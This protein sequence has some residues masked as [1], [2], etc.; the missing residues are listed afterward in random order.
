MLE[1]TFF[2][3]AMTHDPKDKNT[4]HVGSPNFGD[5]DVFNKYVDE[6]FE[7]RWFTNS[8]VVEQEFEQRLCEY[9]GVKHCIP[10]C[11]ATIGLQ[12]CCHALELTG[13]VIV[14]SFTFVAT[15]H[16]VKWE[17]L[18]P[19]FADVDLRSHTVCPESVESLINEKTSAIIGVHVWGHPC[20]TNRLD[21]IARRH[22]L[23]LVYDAAHAF[24]CSHQGKMIGNFGRCEVFSFHATKFFNT[25]E[26]G[27]IATNDDELAEKIRLMKNF[28]FDGAGQV[29]HLGTNAKMTEIAAAMGISVFA[30]LDEIL[31]ANKSNY[32]LYRELFGSVAGINMFT[33]EHL[34][35]PNWQYIV[36]EI[37]EARFGASRDQVFEHLRGQNI[38]AKRY[39]HPG[40]HQMEPYR[41]IDPRMVDRLAST[42]ELCNRVLCLPNGTAIT[43]KDVGIVFD[44]IRSLSTNSGSKIKT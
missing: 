44:A 12:L 20:D 40:C 36:I 42:N 25:F 34:E 18:T 29:V 14:P 17:G 2:S 15:P 1:L 39:F 9:L 16:A 30:K 23:Q 10:V 27:A 35:G 31:Q 37:D 11:N 26:G 21:Q 32:D 24:G 43:T 38:F 19:V 28:G 3:F 7:R 5:R 22:G 33:Y 13:E 6:I 41:T 8:G 4:L